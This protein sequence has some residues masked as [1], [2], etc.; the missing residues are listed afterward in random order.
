[1]RVLLVY[2]NQCK[3][4][5][6]APPVGLSYIASATKLAGHQVKFLDLLVAKKPHKLLQKTIGEFKPNVV[7]ISV[8]NIDNILCQRT[9]NHLT[10]LSEFLAL[11]RQSTSLVS[12]EKIQVV[13]GG[14]AISI[15]EEL[16][17]QHLDADFAICGEG[18]KSFP[19]LLTALEN[20][21]DYSE[22]PGLC[23][24]RDGIILKNPKEIIGNFGSSGMENWI[25]WRL[26]HNKGNACWAIQS[27]RGCPFKCEYCSYPSI[28]GRRFRIRSVSE[29][30]NEIEEVIKKVGP[31]T[32]E[33]VDSTFNVPQSHAI[34]LC[35]E[36][37]R[38]K[39]KANF[40]APGVNPADTS[41]E[42][43]ALMKRAGFNSMMVTP[44]AANNAMLSSYNKG[45]D[46]EK[47]YQ[48]AKFIRESGIHSTWFFL[49]GGPGETQ[50]SVNETVAFVESELTD[51]QALSIFMVGIRVFPGTGVARTAYDEGY[52]KSDANLAESVFY[53]SPNV[54]EQWMIHRINQA[55][56][57]Q[58]NVVLAA[59]EGQS[60][61]EA[62]MHKGLR[63][64][65][66]APPY[67]RFLPNMLGV[68]LLHSLRKHY[69][70]KNE[71][72]CI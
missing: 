34:E 7:G 38:R 15:L 37:I 11:I 70:K 68:P 63:L 17:L 8:R 54:T 29:V 42:L 16:S 33:F 53:I 43:F 58:P 1:M 23:Y 21:T 49:L 12:G 64:L 20:Q 10:M 41:A 25:D 46:M 61:I 40:T 60:V 9:Q 30:V 39:V 31:R 51:K 72:P 4:L 27:K 57:K 6:L 35:E 52:L 47:V 2:S 5:T 18:E 36:I 71:V 65:G 45:F 44:E 19:T 32:F 50:D 59:D 13:L 48:T 22:I 3:D 69:L 66:V 56:Q 26:Y 62:A 55:V 28:E 14:P 24:R 67:W